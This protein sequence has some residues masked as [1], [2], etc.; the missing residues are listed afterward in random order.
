MLAEYAYVLKEN[1]G[2]IYTITDV[3]D[4]HEWM[5]SHLEA[6][7]L[8]ERLSQAELDSD[9]VVEKLFE[10]TEE[11]KKVT[12]AKGE[13]WCSVFRRIPDPVAV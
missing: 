9:P 1:V 7:P 6:H 5:T 12:R 2:L 4:L 3:H 13:K 8:F 10:S 11:G